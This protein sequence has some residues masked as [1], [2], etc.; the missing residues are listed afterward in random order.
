MAMYILYIGD[1]PSLP[2]VT[3]KVSTNGDTS[4]LVDKAQVSYRDY[5]ERDMLSCE[6][7]ALDLSHSLIIAIVESLYKR[8]ATESASL[9][10][11]G[12]AVIATHVQQLHST[13]MPIL[14][15][16]LE[17]QPVAFAMYEK[18]TPREGGL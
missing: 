13:G 2:N 18:L 12:C 10:S 8:V 9:G 14:V 4:E 7:T 16:E 3:P 6:C 1:R 5:Q 11:K 15:A 17:G